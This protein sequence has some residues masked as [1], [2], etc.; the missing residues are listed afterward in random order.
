[1]LDYSPVKLNKNGA[2]MNPA[3]C[4]EQDYIQFLIAT[5]RTYSCTEAARVSP[6]LESPPSHDSFTR[7]LTRSEPK[8]EALWTEVAPEITKDSG[9]LVLDDSTLDKLYAKKMDLVYYHWSGKHHAVVKGIN[10]LTLIWTDGDGYIPCDHRIPDKN[11]DHL[12]KNAHFRAV[13]KTAKERGFQPT[14]VVF[15]SWYSSLENLKL[16]K[17]FEWIWL[18][19]LKS[20]RQINP[21][22]T[23]NR[24]ISDVSLSSDGNIV[25]LKG[26]GL[27]KVFRIVARNGD[28]EYWATNDL[29]MSNLTRQSLAERR[30]M[31]EVYH[32]DLKQNCGVERC[33]ARSGIAQRNHIGF[34]IRAFVRLERYFYRTGISIMEAKNKIIRNAVRFYLS[35]PLYNLPATA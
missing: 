26:Y 2:K 6:K 19:Q 14:A 12:T 9:V 13:L 1:M 16:I 24:A 28:T 11:T 8:P 34:A 30:W 33:Q 23:K 27:V 21:D 4:T 17:D 18:T 22:R 7:L 15:D 25:H 5:P 32:R 3:K 20:N 35:A 31:I 10:L 29:S